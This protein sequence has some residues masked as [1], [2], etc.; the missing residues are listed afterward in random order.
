MSPTVFRDDAHKDELSAVMFRAIVVLVKVIKEE[1]HI[2]QIYT[3]LF[4][5]ALLILSVVISGNALCSWIKN[6]KVNAK[7][8]SANHSTVTS[9]FDL[10]CLFLRLICSK[11]H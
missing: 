10:I 11:A 9:K 1:R 4:C 2:N 7:C 8:K 3:S 6:I 5:T